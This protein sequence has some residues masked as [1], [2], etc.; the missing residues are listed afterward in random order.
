MSVSQLT[1]FAKQSVW[2]LLHRI[3]S[4]V[5]TSYR[6]CIILTY[7]RIS[8][9]PSPDDPLIVSVD[10][11]AKHVEFLKCHFRL[12]SAYEVGDIVRSRKHF[13]D[14]SCLITFDDGWKDNYTHAFPVLQTFEAPAIIFLATGYIGTSKRFWHDR[15]SSLLRALPLSHVGGQVTHHLDWRA[16]SVIRIIREVSAIPVRLRRP[17]IEEII[18]AWKRFEDSEREQKIQEIESTAGGASASS[19]P[20]MLSWN[21]VAVMA[22]SG[23]EFGSHTVSHVLLDQVSGGE[24]REELRTSKEVLEHRLK[25]PVNFVAYPNGNYNDEVLAASKECGY[26]G[27]FTCEVGFNVASD[28]PF[29]LKRKHVLNELSIG[30]N[31]RFSEAFFAA[32]LSGIRHAVKAKIGCG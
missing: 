17:V 1:L 18:Q 32:E 15:L 23:I 8:D 31:G 12:L 21:D 28:S 22:C 26:L 4:K 5:S 29:I 6:G 27:G 14:C 7:H 13:P 3:T 10:Q 30:W 11:F 25:Q 16:A 20:A 24:M 2:T 9:E 19:T